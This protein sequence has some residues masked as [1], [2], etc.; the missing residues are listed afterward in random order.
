MASFSSELI[1]FANPALSDQEKQLLISIVDC[2]QNDLLAGHSCS[3]LPLVADKISSSL[4]N[5][6]ELLLS[7]G[8]V[9][10]TASGSIDREL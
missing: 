7:S 3:K 8:L 2:V 4:I 1:K 6:R 10:I 9:A 5:V